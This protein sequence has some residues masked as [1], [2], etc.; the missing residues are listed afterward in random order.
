MSKLASDG[1]WNSGVE[2]VYANGGN[3][4][5]TALIEKKSRKI[6]DVGC[7]AGDNARQITSIRPDCRVYGVTHSSREAEIALPFLEQC[8]VFDIEAAL[9]EDLAG[10]QFDTLIL[11]HVLEHLRNPARVLAEFLTLLAP[12]GI[13]LIAVP[14]ILMWRQRLRFLAG[15]FEYEDAGVL[16]DTHLRFFTYFTADRYLLAQAP[17]LRVTYKGAGGSFPLWL[18]RRHVLPGAWCKKIDSWATRCWPNLFGSQIL[19]KAVHQGPGKMSHVV[20]R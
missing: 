18:L 1:P 6:L 14:N 17:D 9:P 7:G 12:G 20:N 8:W 4:D 13:V 2:R 15:S 10:E 11:S 3:P 16:D 5:L 19:I